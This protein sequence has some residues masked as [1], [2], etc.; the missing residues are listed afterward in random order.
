M[1]KQL[2]YIDALSRKTIHLDPAKICKEK[3]Y[4]VILSSF[5]DIPE[6]ATALNME[7]GDARLKKEWLQ[8]SWTANPNGLRDLEFD[9]C[10]KEVLSIEYPKTGV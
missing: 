5:E 10:W 8:F 9:E 7:I 3:D 6:I 1:Q 4:S 2:P